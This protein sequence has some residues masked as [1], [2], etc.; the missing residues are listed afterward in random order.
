MTARSKAGAFYPESILVIHQ[1]VAWMELQGNL[2]FFSFNERELL[3]CEELVDAKFDLVLLLC[4][5]LY[6]EN[7][8]GQ[9][10]TN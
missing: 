2:F 1:I 4:A 8:K 7:K 3:S 6:T 10:R 5:Q 9:R